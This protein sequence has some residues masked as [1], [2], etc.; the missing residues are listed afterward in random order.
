M[1]TSDLPRDHGGTTAIP[2]LGQRQQADRREDWEQHR[3]YDQRGSDHRRLPPLPGKTPG[4]RR[5]E[6][7]AHDHRPAG[8]LRAVRVAINYVERR[9]RRMLAWHVGAVETKRRQRR[10]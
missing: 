2:P 10:S 3:Q 1:P 4:A 7:D 8:I 9:G 6:S 5:R